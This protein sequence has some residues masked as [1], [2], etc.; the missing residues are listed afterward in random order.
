MSQFTK[1][2]PNCHDLFARPSSVCA[3]AIASGLDVVA[4]MF[5]PI[6]ERKLGDAGFI[7]FA[8]SLRDHPVVLLPGRACER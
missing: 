5:V 6:F 1:L 7:E 2:T 8:Q 3:S 4:G